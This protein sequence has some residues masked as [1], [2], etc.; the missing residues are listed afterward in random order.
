MVGAPGSSILETRI[1]SLPP[2]DTLT[3]LEL[4]W[5][6]QLGRS[7]KVFLNTI[8]AF[9]STSWTIVTASTTAAAGNRLALDTS[10]GTFN[11]SLPGSPNAGDGIELADP[12]GSWQANS[13]VL[14]QNG[15]TIEGLSED[16]TLSLNR[17]R[18]VLLYD[19]T[20]WRVFGE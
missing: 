17:A 6:T 3:G 19:G 14:L 1:P 20:T 13:P 4:L 15:H 9:A 7:K 5:L 10:R 11:V 2:A 12:N 16:M 18:V 8:R